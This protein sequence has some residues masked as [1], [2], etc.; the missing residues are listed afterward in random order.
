M[1]TP[2]DS[3]EAPMTTK[4]E[5]ILIRGNTDQEEVAHHGMNQ[6]SSDGAGFVDSF[7]HLNK[8]AFERTLE[9]FSKKVEEGHIINRVEETA[10][11]PFVLKLLGFL[12]GFLLFLLLT[13]PS[14]RCLSDKADCVFLAVEFT[15]ETESLLDF[16]F[17]FFFLIISFCCWCGIHSS[18]PG[19]DRGCFS[20]GTNIGRKGYE[21]LPWTSFWGLEMLHSVCFIISLITFLDLLNS[22]EVREIGIGSFDPDSID[23]ILDIEAYFSDLCACDLPVL[24]NVL[25]PF[26]SIFIFCVHTHKFFYRKQQSYHSKKAFWGASIALFFSEDVIFLLMTNFWKENDV[27]GLLAK[28]AVILFMIT[29]FSLALYRICFSPAVFDEEGQSKVLVIRPLI[30]NSESTKSREPGGLLSMGGLKAFVAQITADGRDPETGEVGKERSLIEVKRWNAAEVSMQLAHSI[31]I[32]PILHSKA[33]GY[34][35]YAVAV[36]LT[37]SSLSALLL[38]NIKFEGANVTLAEQFDDVEIEL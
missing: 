18:C 19:L 4:T 23:L 14:F 30:G 22:S 5:P 8:G 29:R 9:L 25:I 34:F 24:E 27:T 28:I 26:V 3:P 13:I 38:S 1:N 36:L 11:S 10:T 6:S 17:V 12:I 33:R 21:A 7:L 35:S 31:K 16:N 37:L 15:V 2:Q 20:A 32:R